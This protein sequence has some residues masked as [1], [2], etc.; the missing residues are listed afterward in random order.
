M[1]LLGAWIMK[2]PLARA[3]AT[4]RFITG[5]SS[6]TRLVAP[7]HQ[8]SFHMSQMMMAVSVGFHSTSF[9]STTNAF[10]PAGARLA[11]GSRMR[12]RSVNGSRATFSPRAL[13]RAAIASRAL[14]ANTKFVIL[15]PR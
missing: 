8:C 15:L 6:P 13:A 2:T 4:V 7:L 3:A 9:S 10:S 1:Q 11:S 14:Q 12:A 5:A